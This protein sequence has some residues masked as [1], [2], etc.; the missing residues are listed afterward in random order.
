MPW[1]WPKRTTQSAHKGDLEKAREYALQ[2]KEKAVGPGQESV[3]E[4][5]AKLL[6]QLDQMARPDGR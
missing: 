5:V 1:P 4:T 2:A 3:A 6:A